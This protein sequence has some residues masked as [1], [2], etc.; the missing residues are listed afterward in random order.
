MTHSTW[1][2]GTHPAAITPR[3]VIVLEQGREDLAVAFWE[4][5]NA[6]ADLGALLQSLTSAFAADLA[7]LPSFVAIVNESDTAHIALRGA[8]ELVVRTPEGAQSLTSGNVITW[9]E[10]RIGRVTGWQVNCAMDPSDVDGATIVW[11]ALDAVVPVRSITWGELGA[12][13][14][15]TILDEGGTAQPV[16]GGEVEPAL[17]EV[18]PMP[19][20]PEAEPLSDPGPRAGDDDVDEPREWDRPELTLSETLLDQGF[21][22]V[23]QAGDQEGDAEVTGSGA[24]P[25]EVPPAGPAP[26]EPAGSAFA[27]LFSDHT[28][29]HS[30][31]D[32]AVRHVRDSDEVSGSAPAE[33]PDPMGSQPA[34]VPDPG[35]PHALVD[36]AQAPEEI[37]D[38]DGHTVRSTRVDEL[39]AAARQL[40]ESAVPGDSASPQVLALLCV[41][42][43][44]NPTHAASCRICGAP[45]ADRSVSIPR[46]DLGSLVISTGERIPLDRDIVIGRRPRYVPQPGRPEAHLVPVPSPNQQISR[47]HCEVRV[48]GWDV[49]VRDLGSNNGTFL[50]RPGEA[51]VRITESAPVIVRPGDVIDLGDSVTM[52]VEV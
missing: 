13:L 51:P 48:D 11:V 35:G 15:Q 26:L 3:G 9:S 52:R 38:H 2:A 44:P 40:S 4:Q 42:G 25:A 10:H 30:V 21:T 31:E 49:R 32:A 36:G 1:T 16:G 22:T 33:V 29:H 34:P 39:R 5:L 8:F 45:M 19:A 14:P 20:P 27:E 46:P 17:T 6:G 37:G 41:M 24:T 43:H 7:A 12:P 50:M 28:V 23:G 47:S 18:A